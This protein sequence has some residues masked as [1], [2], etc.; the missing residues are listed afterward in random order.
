VED[1]LWLEVCWD[2]DHRTTK[3]RLEAVYWDIAAG[4]KYFYS[5][6]HHNSNTHFRLGHRGTGGL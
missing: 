1:D 2:W 3:V 6:I 4:K 5:T